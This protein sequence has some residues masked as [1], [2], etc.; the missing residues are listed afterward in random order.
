MMSLTYSHMVQKKQC[1]KIYRPYM[2]T[3]IIIYL[4]TSIIYKIHRQGKQLWQNWVK[5]VW[6]IFVLFL[7]L[8]F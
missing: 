1:K 7:K 8:F 2:Y 4:D 5:S 6:D 3:Y